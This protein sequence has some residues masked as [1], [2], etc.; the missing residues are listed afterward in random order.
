MA[1]LQIGLRKWVVAWAR[2]RSCVLAGRAPV[3]WGV[4]NELSL[5][6][7]LVDEARAGTPLT[8]IVCGEAGVG[9]RLVAEV[10]AVARN[11]EQ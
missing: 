1:A 3:S 5:L 9:L 10:T 7:E 8:V 11:Q 4:W 6:G 2:M